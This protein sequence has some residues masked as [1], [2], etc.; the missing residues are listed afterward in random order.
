[1]RWKET[2]LPDRVRVTILVESPEHAE[3]LSEF[4]PA[5]EVQDAIPVEYEPFE[6]E[7]DPF[8]DPPPG[9]IATLMYAAIYGIAADVVVR[10]TGGTGK[11]HSNWFGDGRGRSCTP[12]IVDF[13]D[14]SGMREETDS[15]VRR[16]EYYEGYIRELKPALEKRTMRV[17]STVAGPSII[18]EICNSGGGIPSSDPLP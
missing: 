3:W 11:L 17:N 18:L 10:A 5:W 15:D 2:E 13:R 1:M 6:V 9:R 16:Y 12:L 8:A 4:L 14:L 7:D